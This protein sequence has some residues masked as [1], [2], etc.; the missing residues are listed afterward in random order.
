MTYKDLFTV[1]IKIFALQ[2]LVYALS[3]F[4]SSFVGALSFGMNSDNY[5]NT[6]L[7]VIAFV[8]QVAV[9][10]FLFARA[11]RLVKFLKLSQGFE[12]NKMEW[13]GLQA[14]HILKLGIF[15]TGGLM[16]INTLPGFITK[17]LNLFQENLHGNAFDSDHEW[18][19]LSLAFE[20][21]KLLISYLLITNFNWIANRFQSQVEIHAEA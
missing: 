1:L 15:V 16:F 2:Y 17:V 21:L 11:N 19:H 10:L 8:L 9:L 4:T 12:E 13:K 20:I 6:I 5:W 18:P 7:I 3:V 14:S